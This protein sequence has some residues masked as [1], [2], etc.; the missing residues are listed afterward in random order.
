MENTCR[1]VD[2]SQIIPGDTW[3][4]CD[5]A[6]IK[7]VVDSVDLDRQEVYYSWQEDGET[8][9]HSKSSF[10]FQVRYYKP[11]MNELETTDRVVCQH[12]HEPT[13]C[14]ECDDE[15]NKNQ[16]LKHIVILG[17]K[18]VTSDME[19]I[20]TDC[21]ERIHGGRILSGEYLYIVERNPTN[22]ANS[23]FRCE[24]CQDDF[25]DREQN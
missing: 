7:V 20:C 8:V 9:K 6:G 14:W 1:F 15:Q 18:G 5:G 2:A 23:R 10:S 11:D 12:F 3:F 4:S 13:N 21:N 16:K 24:C 19:F 25:E 17:K 22:P